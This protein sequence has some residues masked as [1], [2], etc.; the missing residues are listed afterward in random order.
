VV[1][2]KVQFPLPGFFRHIAED[3]L[4]FAEE[5]LEAAEKD[6]RLLLDGKPRSDTFKPE[7]DPVAMLIESAQQVPLGRDVIK[8]D[9]ESKEG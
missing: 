1:S 2:S 8:M 7:T 4:A 3:R 6:I 5:M 9:D